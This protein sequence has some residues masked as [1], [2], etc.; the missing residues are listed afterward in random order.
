MEET[1][2]TTG[3]NTG[4][5]VSKTAHTS[6]SDS[7]K[8][9][10]LPKYASARLVGSQ[11]IGPV[12]DPYNVQ[13]R[14]ATHTNN[15]QKD[16]VG[17][18]QHKEISASPKNR[19]KMSPDSTKN[20][21]IVPDVDSKKGPVHKAKISATVTVSNSFDTLMKEQD[22]DDIGKKGQQVDR[23]AIT[24][25][26]QSPSSGKQ[27]QQPSN[28]GIGQQQQSTKNASPKSTSMKQNSLVSEGEN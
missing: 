24:T 16:A 18:M 27:Q 28:T 19:Q 7:V 2:S 21:K 23:E 14:N 17:I 5:A 22:L 4:E 3:K 10:Q 1:R 12:N 11:D 20:Q 8:V 25:N 15:D 6:C 26:S 9:Q 13:D